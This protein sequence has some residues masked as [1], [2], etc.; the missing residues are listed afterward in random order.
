MNKYPDIFWTVG[1]DSNTDMY[2]LCTNEG[3]I[4]DY[5]FPAWAEDDVQKIC[6]EHNAAIIEVLRMK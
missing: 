4:S 5:R 2:Y 6:D 1:C 3:R